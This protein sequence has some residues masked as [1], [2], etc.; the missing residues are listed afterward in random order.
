MNLETLDH[1]AKEIVSTIVDSYV[2]GEKQI[3]NGTNDYLSDAG[4]YVHALFVDF[5]GKD[6]CNIS[7]HKT[8][9]DNVSVCYTFSPNMIKKLPNEDDFDA[10]DRYVNTERTSLIYKITLLKWLYESGY[11]FLIDDKSWNLFNTGNITSHD[12]EQWTKYGIKFYEETL[13][14]RKIFDTLSEFHNCRIIPSPQ[15]INYRNNKFRTPEQRRFNVN[16]T[17]SVAAIIVSFIIGIGSPWLMTKFSKTSI[18]SAQLE[19]IITAIPKQLE[20]VKLNQEQMDSI[21][22]ILNKIDKPDNGQT[23]NAKP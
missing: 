8:D 10:L 16:S 9:D 4:I 7:F 11:V 20:E 3:T 12:K 13:K 5:N 18:E 14:S 19:S 21:I 23:E 6:L 15:L 22:T 1:K 2:I 17:I